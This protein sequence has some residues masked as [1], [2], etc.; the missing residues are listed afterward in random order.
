MGEMRNAYDVLVG[1]RGGKRPFGR[2][3]HG[4]EGK[5]SVYLRA[6]GWKSVDWMHLAQERDQW[7][8]LVYTVVNLV[9]T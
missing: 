4:W 9:I 2:P 3:R 5:I 8:Y 1:K 7:R 6:V